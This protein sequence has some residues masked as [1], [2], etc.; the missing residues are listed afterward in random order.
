MH[1]FVFG[2]PDLQEDSLPLRIIPALQKEFSQMHFITVDPNEEWDIPPAS[3]EHLLIIDT[4]IGIADVTVFADLSKFVP[5]PRVSM[6]DFDA[7]ANLRLL[8][9]LGKINKVTV[10]A[11]PMGMQENEA[12][13]KTIPII[14]H[15]RS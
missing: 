1:I 11:I 6:H 2:N 4:A 13:Q 7:L 15:L 12:T 9:K 8:M 3:Q 5:A 14:N 10:I